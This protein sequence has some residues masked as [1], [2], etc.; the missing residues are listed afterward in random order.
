M[1]IG[2]AMRA[3]SRYRAAVEKEKAEREAAERVLSSLSMGCK[4][5]ASSRVAKRILL[6]SPVTYNGRMLN[7]TAKSVG[8]GVYELTAKELAG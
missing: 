3:M 7:I 4:P 6:M 8:A 2:G 5:R 1:N